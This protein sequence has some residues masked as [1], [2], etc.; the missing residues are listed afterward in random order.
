MLM[1]VVLLYTFFNVISRIKYCNA[2]YLFFCFFFRNRT[3]ESTAVIVHQ[4]KLIKSCPSV[5]DWPTFKIFRVRARHS[6]TSL[7]AY[8]VCSCTI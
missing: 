6:K 7:F 8:G 5:Q 2:T 1:F 3:R 4:S